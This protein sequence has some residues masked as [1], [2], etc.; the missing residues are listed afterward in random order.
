MTGVRIRRE[1]RAGHITLAR[2][3]ALN[4]L[5]GAMAEAM[6]AAFDAFA[7]DAS[8]RLVILDAEGTRAFCAGG[9]IRHIYTT[10]R[11]GDFA[12]SRAFF[13]AE[14][15]LN[16]RIAGFP[17]PVVPLIQ[18][19]CMGGG[20]GLAGHAAHRVIGETVQVAMPECAI[21]LVPDVGA[22]HLLARAPG[23]LGEYLGLTGHR[24]GP[25]DALHAGFADLFVPQAAWPE[26]V[27]RLAETGDP[28]IVAAFAEASPD[29]PLQAR[30]DEIEAAFSAPDLATLAARLEV[31]D[32]GHGVLEIL[33]RQSPLS[34]AATLALVRAARAEPGVEA[35]LIRE[36]RFAWRAASEGELLEGIRAAVIDKDRRP[37]W[38]H[39]MDDLDPAEVAAMLAPLG[40]EELELG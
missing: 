30:G 6:L 16:A 5:D 9:D 21:G 12:P 4:A 19:F 23:R 36:H 35:A 25:G 10:G 34:M 11:R 1:G 24:M 33:A 28:D 17:K 29:S 3:E 7:T 40:T 38:R 8:L 15:R 18:G 2:P 20:V 31:G 26:L 13:A 37:Q 14:Y 27:A 32:W 22:S 39:A